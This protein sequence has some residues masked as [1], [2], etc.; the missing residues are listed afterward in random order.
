MSR[1][2]RQWIYFVVL[3]SA[4]A[5]QRASTSEPDADAGAGAGAPLDRMQFSSARRVGLETATDAMQRGDV[6]QLKQLSIWVRKR[7]QVAIFEPDDLRSLDLAIACLE[8]SAT[9]S[10]AVAELDQLKSGTLK[11]PARQTCASKQP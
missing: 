8:R 11:K 9:P 3:G 4:L 10:A 6:E 5:C 2:R 7:A 1:A